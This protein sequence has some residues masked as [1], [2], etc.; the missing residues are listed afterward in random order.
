V[1]RRSALGRVLER[2]ALQ[3]GR[4]ARVREHLVADDLGLLKCQA[5]DVRVA[6]HVFA[7][8]EAHAAAGP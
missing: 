3:I 5:E 8:D 7:E 1:R 4:L 6:D 2:D